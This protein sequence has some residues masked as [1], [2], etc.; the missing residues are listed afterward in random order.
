M[1]ISKEGS[2]HFRKNFT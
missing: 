1:S 2:N